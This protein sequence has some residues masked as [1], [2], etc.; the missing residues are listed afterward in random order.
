LAGLLPTAGDFDWTQAFVWWRNLD[1][2]IHHTNKVDEGVEHGVD[3]PYPACPFSNTAHHGWWCYLQDGRVNVFYSTP[4]LY[5]EAK[6]GYNRT[7]PVHVG[8]MFPYADCVQCY[9]TGAPSC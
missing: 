4:K 2:I 9:W 5:T 7:W 1:K 8:D 3:L 6:K